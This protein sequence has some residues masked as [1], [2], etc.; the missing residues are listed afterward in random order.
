[1]VDPA[2]RFAIAVDGS[3]TGPNNLAEWSVG[4]SGNLTLIGT[5][6]IPGQ[7][8]YIVDIDPSGLTTKFETDRFT[9]TSL[10]RDRVFASHRYQPLHPIYGPSLRTKPPPIDVSPSATMP[11]SGRHL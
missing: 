9:S 10:Q 5:V 1:M 2:S 8:P 11:L 3:L 7:F 6:G 4:A